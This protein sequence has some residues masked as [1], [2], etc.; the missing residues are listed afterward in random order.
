MDLETY[1]ERLATLAVEV[2]AN[3]QN[4]QIVAISYA[5]GMDQLVHAI[6][7][8]AYER[9]AKFVDPF[10]FDGN[11]KRIRLETAREDTLEFVP[12]WWGQR[13]LGLG[14]NKAARIAIAPTPDPG[15]LA[16]IDP[17]RA[18]KDDLPFVKETPILIK[19]RSTNW[20]IVPY[21]TPGWATKVHPDL[22]PDE[23]LQKLL[24][25]LAHILRLDEDDPSAAWQARGDE[26]IG[27]GTRMTELRFDAIRL[28]GEGTDLK[29]GLFHGS[30]WVAARNHTAWGC[31]HYANL[32]SEEIFTTP[33][34]TRTEGKVTATKPLDVSGALIEGLKVSFERGRVTRIDADS[35]ADVLRGRVAK[36][37]GAS[38]LG[39]L[40]LVDRAGRIAETGSVFFNTLLDENAAS[41]IALGSAYRDAVE[42]SHW[43]QINDSQIH[44]DFMIGSPEVDVFGLDLEGN[45][46]PVL[47]GGD[48]QI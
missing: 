45:E 47:I 2:G 3:V 11:I 46:T 6:A 31:Q 15:V 23:A 1:C 26:L 18:G 20:T 25:Q 28:R 37:D 44:I 13:V 12:E 21:P 36:D 27:V 29:V 41:H 10:V 39:E 8:K 14:E 42:E 9:G 34:P 4:D 32:P 5:P 33:D 22:G 38:R 7:R 35:G 17:E 30:K 16:G 19:D 43:G 40:A 24:D 48:W